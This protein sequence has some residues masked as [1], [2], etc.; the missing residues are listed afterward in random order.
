MVPLLQAESP[1]A[2]AC[3]VL[4]SPRAGDPVFAAAVGPVVS[5]IE[6]TNDPVV[7]VPP[8]VWAGAGAVFP[9]PGPGPVAH[10]QPAGTAVTIADDGTITPGPN[11]QT[12]TDAVT[13]FLTWTAPTH[14]TSV[15]VSRL[16]IGLALDP[17]PPVIGYEA[18]QTMVNVY[19]LLNDNPAFPEEP[20][21]SYLTQAIMYFRANNGV[22]E[23]WEESVY[24]ASDVPT[25]LQLL[26][27]PMIQFRTA[28]LSNQAEIHAYRAARAD[29]V[30][31]SQTV[32]MLNVSKG[33]D[34]GPVD[35]FGDCINAEIVGAQQ[36]KRI[37]SFRGIPESY[38]AGQ[39][40]T[41]SG[42][43]GWEKAKSYLRQ[44]SAQGAGFKI[45]AVINPVMD[46][47][48]I[49]NNPAAGGPIQITT[50]TPHNLAQG[51]LVRVKGM[52]GYP[53]LNAEWRVQLVDNLNFKL[54]GSQRYN[55]NLLTLTG[56]F[57]KIE[58]VPDDFQQWSFSGVS[59]RKTGVPFGH[60]RGKR[61]AK[62]LHR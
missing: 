24:F 15:Y 61:S 51:D 33:Q 32:K 55:V 49:A 9:V 21:V 59:Y 10:Y 27:N 43:D 12:L 52:R 56:K 11:G 42:Q 6:N 4:G 35:E 38:I 7:A 36:E 25:V 8:D 17:I 31:F 22:T 53:Y 1:D 20:T 19:R 41:S 37:Y 34:P 28:F 26:L 50:T 46:I 57:Q 40:L 30:R 45:P 29:G 60:P 2:V 16:A 18:A 54:T 13:A 47:A 5:R 48:I 58:Y 44:I 39:A 62:L 23:G 14:D 3:W